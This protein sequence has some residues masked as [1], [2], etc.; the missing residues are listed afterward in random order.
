MGAFASND[1]AYFIECLTLRTWAGSVFPHLLWRRFRGR[2][3]GDRCYVFEGSRLALAVAR[4]SVWAT[5]VPVELLQFRL[6]DVLDEDGLLL[7][8]R[9]AYQNLAEVQADVVQD[10]AFRRI[11]ELH[12][13]E[14]YVLVYLAKLIANLSLFDRETLGRTLLTVQVCRWKVRQEPLNGMVPLLFL[15]RRPWLR[16]ITRYATR[17]QVM[18]VPVGPSFNAKKW[19]RQLPVPELKVALRWVRSNYLQWVERRSWKGKVVR[20]LHRSTDRHRSP[21]LAVEFYGHL[22]LAQ[23]E[24]YSDLFF[25]QQSSLPAED[26]LVTFTIAEDP[27]DED[28]WRE[29]T[30]HGFSAVAMRPQATTLPWVPVF[31]PRPRLRRERVPARLLGPTARSSEGHWLR[32]QLRD[33]RVLRSSWEEF[34]T[35]MGVK[36]YVSW[37]KYDASHCVIADALQRVGGVM[38]IYQRAYESH[39]SAETTITADVVFGFSQGAAELERRSGSIIPYHVTTGYLGDHRFPLLRQQAQAMRD[40]LQQKGATHLLTFSDENSHDEKRWMSGHVIMRESYA[41]LLDKVL[42]EPWFGL[43]IKPKVPLTLR[44]RLGPVLELLQRAEAS[45]RCVV[46]E[47]GVLHGSFPPAAAALASD[48]MIHGHLCAATAGLEGAL[49]GVPTLLMDREGWAVSP[50]YRLG[51]GRVVFTCWPDLW[52]ACL[53]HWRSPGGV[54]GFGDW[55]PMLDELDPFRDGRAAERMG[56]YLQWLLEGFKAGLSR[57]TVLADAAERYGVIWG[58]DKIRS[59]NLQPGSASA[60]TADATTGFPHD[61]SVGDIPEQAHVA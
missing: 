57:E 22:N 51:V 2:R 6:L 28:K 27:L 4:A 59:V 5:G 56:T 40:R 25:W 46:Y 10:P 12:P 60:P 24:R 11:D 3:R 41:F 26:V 23:P 44:R 16:A 17:H 9:V 37:F 20:P 36:M 29:I 31:T 45:G 47:E 61:A 55:S 39:P 30:E 1:I 43:L 54:P 42:T 21:R 7:R 33:Y 8:L 14:R 19:F 38:A 52:K 18:T 48:V 32:R 15:E 58:K 34:F 49:A 13:F 53:E 50:L 35:T